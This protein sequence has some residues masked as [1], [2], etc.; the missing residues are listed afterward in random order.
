MQRLKNS[1]LDMFAF[2]DNNITNSKPL[3]LIFALLLRQA[4]F[5][6]EIIVNDKIIFVSLYNF[7]S[8][9]P[10]G[11]IADYFEGYL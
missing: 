9:F 11:E 7:S 4:I 5:F 3:F 1:V 2:S 6:F 8:C 10:V